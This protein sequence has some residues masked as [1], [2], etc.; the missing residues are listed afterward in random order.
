MRYC[1]VVTGGPYLQMATL[2][3]VRTEEPPIRLAAR[4]YEPGTPEQVVRELRNVGDLVVGVGAPLSAG[5]RR[6]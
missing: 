5:P 1:G 4:F 6:A 3:E 2:E